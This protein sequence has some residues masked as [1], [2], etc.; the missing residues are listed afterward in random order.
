MGLTL[1]KEFTWAWY[2]LGIILFAHD[3]LVPLSWQTAVS[4]FAVGWFAV[5]EA[6][7]LGRPKKGDSLTEHWKVFYGGQ[8]LRLIFLVGFGLY[9]AVSLINIRVEP[10]LMIGRVPVTV[11]V[12]ALTLAVWFPPHAYYGGKKG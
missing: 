8:P 11:A 10:N 12:I 7:A 9:A 4:L 5:F 1:K 6:W 3:F 2:I